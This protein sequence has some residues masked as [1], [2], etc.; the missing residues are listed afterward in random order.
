MD[1]PQ[2]VVAFDAAVEDLLLNALILTTPS[3]YLPFKLEV[4]AGAMGTGV[5]Q[6]QDRLCSL[7]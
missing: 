3:F 2:C 4:G 5:V 1:S 7:S 6:L